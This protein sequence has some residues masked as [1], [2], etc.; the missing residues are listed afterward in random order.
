MGMT[1]FNMVM[2][3]LNR[4]WH[5]ALTEFVIAAFILR[6]TTLEQ[7]ISDCNDARNSERR[8]PPTETDYDGP[9]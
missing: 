3:L 5:T 1:L 4:Q 6:I 7:Y 2:A 8:N 9:H